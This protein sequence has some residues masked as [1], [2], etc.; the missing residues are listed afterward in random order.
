MTLTAMRGLGRA[1]NHIFEC[2]HMDYFI[3]DNCHLRLATLPI[4]SIFNIYE[5]SKNTDLNNN[6][7]M[8]KLLDLLFSNDLFRQAIFVSSKELYDQYYKLKSAN[9]ISDEELKRFLITFF[10]YYSRMASRSTP[11]GIFAG[12]SLLTVADGPTKFS[13][14]PDKF[15]VKVQLNLYPIS[16][17]IRQIDTSQGDLYS[18]VRY[19]VNNTLYIIGE[20]IIYVEQFDKNGLPASNLNSILL[21]E[22]TA[23]ALDTAKNGATIDELIKQIPNQE[24]SLDRKLNFIKSLIHSQILVNEFFPS[25]SGDDFV[26]DFLGQ[27]KKQSFSNLLSEE[28]STV[29]ELIKRIERVGDL[30]LIQKFSEEENDR[31]LLKIKNILKTDLT[32]N[33]S[34]Y[35]INRKVIENICET[36]YE[37]LSI[38]EPYGPD[39]DL[40][41]FMARYNEKFEQR[42]M[43]LMVALDPNYGVGYGIIVNGSAD[44]MPLIENVTTIH[45]TINFSYPKP[46]KHDLIVQKVFRKF[47]EEKHSIVKID[48]YVNQML[49]TSKNVPRKNV[50]TSTCIFGSILSDSTEATDN[51]D[52][53]F[54][55]VLNHSPFAARMLAR[56]ANGDVGVKEQLRKIAV[57]EQEVNP[58]IILAE[59]VTIP[60]AEYANICLS[61]VIR[62]YEIP[63][64]SNAGVGNE[65]QININD[66]T[67]AVR[68]GRVV[69]RSIRLDKEIMPCFSNSYNITKAT[70]VYRF[71]ADVCTQSMTYGYN[72]N[73]G[74]YAEETHLPRVEYKNFI[75]QRERWT[76]KKEKVNYD[77]CSELKPHIERLQKNLNLPRYLVL[78]DGDNELFLDIENPICRYILGKEINKK[79]VLLYE[80]LH[81]PR[82][83]FLKENDE[84]YSSAILITMGTHNPMHQNHLQIK[85][86]KLITETVA[87]I[88]PPGSEWLFV[89]I[90]S[91]SKIL[92]KILTEVITE[93]ASKLIDENII[94]KWFF[95]RFNDPNCH[96]RVRFHKSKSPDNNNWYFIMERLQMELTH[97]VKQDHAIKITT[98][99]YNREIERYG[100]ETIENS[101]NIFYRD[102]VAVS[103]FLNLVEGNEGELLRWKFALVNI[104]TL[105]NDFQFDMDEKHHLLDNLSLSFIKEFSGSAKDRESVLLRSLND[106]YRKN[107]DDIVKVLQGRFDRDLNELFDCFEKR[108]LKIKDDVATLN[109]IEQETKNNLLA[110]YIHMSMNRMFLSN[111]R[112]HEL[113]VYHFMK[114]Y[115]R[116]VLAQSKKNKNNDAGKVVSF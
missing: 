20:R 59:V 56:F 12:T 50:T 39:P 62:K 10:K 107:K 18:K 53:K 95:V 104:D 88:F 11:F 87:R 89:K 81:H 114:L 100:A 16:K 33:M 34:S 14:D 4:E 7:M 110:S 25:V 45:Q 43:P 2:F 71:L 37:L 98:D 32:I 79:D 92:E 19:Y 66:I 85:S 57:E 58:H 60:D 15:N 65:F 21:N 13:F 72:W 31:S 26:A 80:F 46:Q 111:P 76:V 3:H 103:N 5:D 93:F 90:Y 113:V 82:N 73:W 105:L 23:S 48:E 42:E 109:T 106:K 67:V 41:S 68:D 55:P 115:Y 84:S 61:P 35:S 28:I 97:Y 64:I 38:K 1:K 75:L 69:L 40:H 17:L 74:A 116:G 47:I 108:S 30:S 29:T 112:K 83:C 99:T 6:S 96:L 101:E 63:Y 86:N 54:L 51:L 78:A 77:N 70:P 9:A 36:S 22:Y 44:Y 8:L 49:D 102:S 91:G 52:F 24:I 27:A 94:D